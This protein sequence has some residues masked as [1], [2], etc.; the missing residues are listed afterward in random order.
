MSTENLA[1]LPACSSRSGY[2][3]QGAPD[4][5][6]LCLVQL[7]I[8]LFRWRAAIWLSNREQE[9]FACHAVLDTA[10]SHLW[11]ASPK[12]MES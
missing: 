1:D 3:K 2:T 11:P 6:V 12:G 7:G 10:W 9:T 4:L 5:I 8:T